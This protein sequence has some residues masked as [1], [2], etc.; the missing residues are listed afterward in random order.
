MPSP[1]TI[2]TPHTPSAL[3]PTE[4]RL[5]SLA[6]SHSANVHAAAAQEFNRP[7]PLDLFD[8]DT[9][10]SSH[11]GSPE[12]SQAP[13]LR[14]GAKGEWTTVLQQQLK[15]AGIDLAVDG[16][17]GRKTQAAVER[18]Q[19]LHGLPP[20]GVVDTSTWSALFAVQGK[21]ASPSPTAPT[22]DLA[23]NPDMRALLKWH[24][25]VR[26]DLY[27][28]TAGKLTI[29]VG[30]NLNAHGSGADIA[31]YRRH[32]A[33][34]QEIER[35][36]TQDIQR[37]T[38]ALERNFGK[39]QWFQELSPNRKMAL[40]DMCFNLGEGGLLK[41]KETL[42]LLRAGKFKAAAAEALDSKWADD[43]G[44]RAQRIAHIIATDKLPPIDR[45]FYSGSSR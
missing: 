14:R 26:S 6:V 17:F 10:P 32:G 44:T 11:T 21:G 29:G 28:C 9:T 4:A 15:G 20:N 27:R 33:S 43:V 23:T 7:P 2:H 39:E 18:F 45:K 41:F 1:V 42:A 38:A 19:S 40:V 3:E 16:T 12:L 13:T 35:W 36:L 31:H 25:G 30:H 24:E 37:A 8:S 5:D 34:P 22:Q